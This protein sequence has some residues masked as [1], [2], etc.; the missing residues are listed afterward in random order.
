MNQHTDSMRNPLRWITSLYLA[1]GL[2]FYAVALVASLMFKSL[3]ISNEQITHWTGFLGLAW[4]FKPLWS[5]LLELSSNK[6]STVIVCQWITGCAFGLVALALQLPSYFAAC[7]AVF[8]LASLSAATHDI[9]A[10]GLYILHLNEYQQARYAGWCGAFFNA[11]KFLSLGGLVILAGYLESRY[12]VRTAWAIIF[13]LL[14]AIM[15]ALG[16]YHW[17]A[18][19]HTPAPAGS[20]MS[21]GETLRDVF[22]D[23]FRKP[24]IWLCI[25][26]IILFRAGEAQVQ[27]IAPLF[28]RDARELGGLGLTTGQIGSVY[29]TA[30]TLT[31]ILGSLGGGYFAAWLGLRRALLPLVLAVNLP[32]LVFYFL[33]TQMPT[34]LWVITAAISVEMLGYGFGFVGLIL[35]IIQVLSVGKYCAAHYALASGIMQLGFVIFKVI[36]G[37][38]QAALGYQHFF[39]WVLLSAVPVTLLVRRMPLPGAAPKQ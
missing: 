5:P 29:G 14:A 23:F 1:E 13:V 28:L 26:F 11:G 32:N 19:P 21:A 33:S 17:R 35:F 30:G 27:T 8:M 31:F 10:D 37:D 16:A 12:P 9:A 36:S 6:K 20:P 4:V 7:I 39:L 3:R 18:I 24:D 38:I 15:L 2:P 34:D 22:S 25:V